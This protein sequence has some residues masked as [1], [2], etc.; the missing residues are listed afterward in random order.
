MSFN[1]RS[2]GDDR[3]NAYH[4]VEN[5]MIESHTNRTTSGIRRLRRRG[6]EKGTATAAFDFSKVGLGLLQ[7]G[8]TEL[9]PEM[10]T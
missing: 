9:C 10:G 4:W 7:C 2:R 3:E 8:P 6:S 5:N 1:T